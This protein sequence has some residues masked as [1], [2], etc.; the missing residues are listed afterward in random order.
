MHFVLG[1]IQ[2]LIEKN[3]I[4]KY[5]SDG[6]SA[7]LSFVSREGRVHSSVEILP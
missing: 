5:I 1:Y 3:V 7:A 2:F 4:R 6:N